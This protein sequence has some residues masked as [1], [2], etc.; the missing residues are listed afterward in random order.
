[1]SIIYEYPIIERI[2][3]LLR[4]EDLFDKAHYFLQRSHPRDHHAALLA[5]FE[6]VEVAG[7]ADVKSDLLQELER[8]RQGLSSFR[9]NP[10]IA[11]D[12]L[13]TVL[14]EIALASVNL[15]RLTGK[16]GQHVRENEWLSG[17]KNRSA[18]PGGTCEFD[19]PAYHHWLSRSVDTRTEDLTDWIAPM[20]PIRD[21][22]AI[23][24]KL[25]RGSGR[26]QPAVA[27]NGQFQQMLAGKTYHLARLKL[28]GDEP[29]V[30]E[31]SANRYAL[32]ARFMVSPIAGGSE[33]DGK[34]RQAL[35]D[36]AFE[37]TLCNL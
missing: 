31:L 27:Q 6:I 14:A 34:S 35:H 12:V 17:I 4:L 20:L 11:H 28:A 36:V 33:G 25:L 19:L 13:E 7:R 30:P 16:A 26:T 2:R 9:T 18:I 24:L 32:M 29:G 21:A 5:I 23:V 10:D 1:M 8:Q 15:N 22:L 37:L 3:T